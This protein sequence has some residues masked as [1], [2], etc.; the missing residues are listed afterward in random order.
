VIADQIHLIAD[1]VDPINYRINVTQDQ[2]APSRDQD[3][4][5]QDHID[6][7]N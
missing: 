6:Q 1:Q 3:D 7:I 4:L 2:D 5:I